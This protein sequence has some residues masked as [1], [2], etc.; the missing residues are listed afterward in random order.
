MDPEIQEL[1]SLAKTNPKAL[2]EL[3]SQKSEKEIID[4]QKRMNP[5]SDVGI[6]NHREE[7]CV[8]LSVT[9][10][11][12]RYLKKLTLTT[13]IG[14]LYQVLREHDEAER[15]VVK[16]FLDKVF[17]YDPTRHIYAL[18]KLKDIKNDDIANIRDEVKAAHNTTVTLPKEAVV[19]T[20]CQQLDTFMT[21]ATKFMER[22]AFVD[23]STVGAFRK[24]TA[25]HETLQPYAKH[26]SNNQVTGAAF[27]VPS[28]DMFH[29][30]NRYQ[31]N[32][33]ESLR[34]INEALYTERP[35]I[36]FSVMVYSAHKSEKE[37]EEWRRRHESRLKGDVFSVP[38][39]K[40]VML[41]P[42]R[43][44]REK[45]D[46][47]TKHTE[48]LKL[49]TEQNE[50]DQKLGKDLMEKRVA[51]EKQKNVAEAGPDAEGLSQYKKN[52]SI[53]QNLGAKAL[54]DMKS[55]EKEQ[56]IKARDELETAILPDGA[57]QVD[58]YFTDADG[59]MQRHYMYTEEVKPEDRSGLEK[60]Q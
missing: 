46:F 10:W 29:S 4:M 15:P 60:K 18:N 12:E 8:N 52:V 19:D 44:N 37:A 26:L 22:G 49:M 51:R 54:S 40:I 14:Y 36:E 47:Y 11:Q 59:K 9:N 24:L 5:L 1:L 32:N 23:E 41:G 31:Q 7:L 6:I 55:D 3:L 28:A 45:L 17:K 33:Y 21:A 13:M 43:Q 39:N 38:N 58:Y 20:V 48:V 34:A 2:E 42:F 25:T 50:Y 53:I 56:F 27:V 57:M 35:D 16:N 30:F